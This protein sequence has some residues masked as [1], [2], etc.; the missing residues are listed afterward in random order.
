MF[1]VVTETWSDIRAV[2]VSLGPRQ[3]Y[4]RQEVNLG[5]IKEAAELSVA[6][7]PGQIVC[8]LVSQ[9]RVS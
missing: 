6:T 9:L 4:T 3:G 1:Q 2:P 7:D 8:M 5:V